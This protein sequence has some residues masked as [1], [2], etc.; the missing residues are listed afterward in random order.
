MVFIFLVTFYFFW[1]TILQ[2]SIYRSD[3]KFP[4]KINLPSQKAYTDLKN[5]IQLTGLQVVGTRG[6]SWEGGPG[7]REAHECWSPGLPFDRWGS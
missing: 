7:V 5:N 6:R 3:S 4:F 2:F 1:Q